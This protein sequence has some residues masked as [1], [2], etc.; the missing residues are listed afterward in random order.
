MLIIGGY[1]SNQLHLYIIHNDLDMTT[2]LQG[3]TPCLCEGIYAHTLHKSGNERNRHA[4]V[5]Y[6]D[7]NLDLGLQKLISSLGLVVNHFSH[8]WS[9][10][11]LN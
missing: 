10:T 4:M 1:K 9:K 7:K 2:V 11:V 3:Y 6:Q 5:V 8:R